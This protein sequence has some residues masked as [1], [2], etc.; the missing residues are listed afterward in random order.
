LID[1]TLQVFQGPLYDNTGVLR[2]PAGEF[3]N[4]DDLLTT[5]DWVVEGVTGQLN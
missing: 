3:L 1:G 2:V 5:A 4:G